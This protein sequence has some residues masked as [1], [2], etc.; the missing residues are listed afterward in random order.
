M[1][2]LIVSSV[3]ASA[4]AKGRLEATNRMPGKHRLVLELTLK[5]SL[6]DSTRGNC[7]GAGF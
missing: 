6:A 5:A 1:I 4:Q 3:N 2:L 7:S